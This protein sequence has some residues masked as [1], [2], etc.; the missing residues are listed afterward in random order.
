MNDRPQLNELGFYVLAGAPESPADC[1]TR[2]RDGEA[3][4]LGCAFISERYNIKEAATLSGA[5]GAV[6]RALRHRHRCD[7]PQHPPPAHHRVV[8]HDH[9]PP[10]RRPLHARPRAWHRRD[11]RRLR[12]PP[13]HDGADGGLRRAVAALVARRGRVRPRRPGRV[14]PDP[15]LDA[16]STRTSRSVSWRSGPTPSRS[17]GGC[18]TWWCCTRSSPTRR[19]TRAS[20]PCATPPSRPGATRVGAH[21]VVLRDDPTTDS[22]RPAAEEDRRTAGHLSAGLRRPVGEHERLG[23]GRAGALPSRC[24]RAVGAAAR[25]T[26]WPTPRPSSTSP[27]SCPT[28]GWSRRPTAAP[29][30][31]AERVLRQFDLGVDGVIMHGATPA[32]LAPVVDAY[33]GIR[34]DR[35]L[36]RARSQPR[37]ITSASD[38]PIFDPPRSS[39]R[40][41]RWRRRHYDPEDLG[42]SSSPGPLRSRRVWS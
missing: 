29:R 11:V 5:A 25:S 10:H 33:R 18:S 20:R 19:P 16:T 23:P 39:G 22:R 28:S 1:S 31:C 36:R 17:P 26:A 7:E 37:P 8:R 35:P 27:R 2:S 40:C 32:E 12:H 30:R 14:V 41:C 15:H 42:R 24:G 6:S 13:D 38:C 3:L 9:A 4:G 21:L 34:P